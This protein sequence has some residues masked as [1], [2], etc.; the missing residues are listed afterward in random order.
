MTTEQIK[1]LTNLLSLTWH[2]S[3]KMIDHCLK[4]SNYI[5]IGEMFVN[6]GDKKPSITK[7]L[8]YD[9][10]TEGPDATE[11]AFMHE[12]E[13][14]NVPG[15][16]ELQYRNYQDLYYLV[17]YHGDKSGGRLVCLTYEEYNPCRTALLR[18]VT[19]E[20]LELIN[21]AV[22]SVRKDYTKRLKA[23]WKRYG[24]DNFR[25]EGYWADR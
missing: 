9:D 10:T 3:Q 23:Y 14:N 1:D 21:E 19:A 15:P 2:G 13:R 7:T 16:W 12:N 8:W 18:K 5:Q 6:C 24:K 11:S 25:V 20:E 4:S 22:E 17:N